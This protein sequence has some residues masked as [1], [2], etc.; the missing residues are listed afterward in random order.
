[1]LLDPRPILNRVTNAVHEGVGRITGANQAERSQEN[2]RATL[3]T[4]TVIKDSLLK[5]DNTGGSD[6]V[7][8][9]TDRL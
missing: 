8:Y 9:P 2:V 5:K 3:R 6:L 7:R 1:M 4:A